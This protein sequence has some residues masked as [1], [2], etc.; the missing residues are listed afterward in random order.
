MR[1]ALARLWWI[2]KLTYDETLSDPWMITKAACNAAIT[3]FVL[4]LNFSSTPTITKTF[5]TALTNAQAQGLQISR[6]IIVEL[7]KYLN[8]LDGTYLLDCMPQDRL[9]QKI[10]RKIESLQEAAAQE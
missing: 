1:N 6:H 9:Y 3:T 8:V 7:A 5:I 2:G 10:Y 4:E